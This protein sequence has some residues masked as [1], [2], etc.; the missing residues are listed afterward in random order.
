MFLYRYLHV[1]RFVDIKHINLSILM[2]FCEVN[3]KE[4]LIAESLLV[5]GIDAILNG[6]DG[7]IRTLGLLLPKQ[8]R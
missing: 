7:E 1:T 8:A 3:K 4:T 6:R 5:I 2:K